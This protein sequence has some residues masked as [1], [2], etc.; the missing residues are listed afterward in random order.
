MRLIVDWDLKPTQRK[1]HSK[2]IARFPPIFSDDLSVIKVA[3][4]QLGIVGRTRVEEAILP[5]FQREIKEVQPR[6][7][8]SFSIPSHQRTQW[9]FESEAR[10][11]LRP[12]LTSLPKDHPIWTDDGR[13]LICM[14]LL[15]YNPNRSGWSDV[16]GKQPRSL[17]RRHPQRDF[18]EVYQSLGKITI[19]RTLAETD[20]LEFCLVPFWAKEGDFIC[21]LIGCSVPVVLRRR[22]DGRYTYVG[23]CY[24]YGKMGGEMVEVLERKLERPN[25]LESFELV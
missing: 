14:L 1:W 22:D 19:C 5:R 17:F 9:N 4:L 10:D 7:H 21:Q 13:I 11:L 3:G 8:L 2:V 25:G 6:E 15:K 12:A 18:A 20:T 16:A 24:V 23:D